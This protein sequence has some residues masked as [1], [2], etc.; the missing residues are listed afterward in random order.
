MFFKYN[1][2]QNITSCTKEEQE[3][4]EEKASVAENNEEEWRQMCGKWWIK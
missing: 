2:R 1:K 3:K 4:T